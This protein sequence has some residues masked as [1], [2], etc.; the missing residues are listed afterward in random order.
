VSITTCTCTYE[1]AARDLCLSCAPD[2]F[3]TVA[4]LIACSNGHDEWGY[5]T[6]AT[7]WHKIYELSAGYAEI[8]SESYDSFDDEGHIECNLCGERYAGEFPSD[9]AW[10]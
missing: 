5:V 9:I 4:E 8:K 6:V 7:Q 2:L 3:G 10:M 1:T